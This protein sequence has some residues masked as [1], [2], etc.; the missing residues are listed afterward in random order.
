MPAGGIAGKRELSN[1]TWRQRQRT[2]FAGKAAAGAGGW[3][4]FALDIGQESSSSTDEQT[5]EKDMCVEALD[6]PCF[7]SRQH[8][9][10]VSMLVLQ[11]A[12]SDMVYRFHAGW[13]SAV[14]GLPEERRSAKTKKK[15]G[16]TRLKGMW[17]VTMV[18]YS[19]E[20]P[21][22]ISWYSRRGPHLPLW[23]LFCFV[24]SLARI[25][26]RHVS[27]RTQE[28][29]DSYIHPHK[30]AVH[31]HAHSRGACAGGCF[32][33]PT[34]WLAIRFLPTRDS[35]QQDTHQ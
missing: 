5:S 33:T 32:S 21:S 26:G 24:R 2:D 11:G 4:T 3:G 7:G 12:Y 10:H 16:R 13:R 6:F 18:C 8:A 1:K 29:A 31:A 35:T 34:H 30:Q 20:V 23:N 9:L 19:S 27:L 22:F 28:P 15:K 14:E 17:V 25:L